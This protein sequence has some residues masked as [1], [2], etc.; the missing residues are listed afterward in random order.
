MYQVSYDVIEDGTMNTVARSQGA[1]AQL[2]AGNARRLREQREWLFSSGS[3]PTSR[4]TAD[5]ELV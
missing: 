3:R 1:V 2:E 4:R 5:N